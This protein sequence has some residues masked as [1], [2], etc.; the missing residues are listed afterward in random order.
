MATNDH[1]A[2]DDGDDAPELITLHRTDIEEIAY[3]LAQLEDCLLHGDDNTTHDISRYLHNDNGA[4]WLARWVGELARHLRS[5]LRSR[6]PNNG[7]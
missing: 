2:L 5:Q 3:L 1:D 6:G 7:P 4:D